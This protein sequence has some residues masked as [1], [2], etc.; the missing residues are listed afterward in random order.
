MDIIFLTI[1]KDLMDL[2]IL[3]FLLAFEQINT[4]IIQE[5]FLI[6]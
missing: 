1:K 4:S 5:I 2:K 6:K 3:V